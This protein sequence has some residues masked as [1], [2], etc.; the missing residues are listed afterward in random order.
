MGRR[1]KDDIPIGAIGCLGVIGLIFSPFFLIGRVVTGDTSDDGILM[2]VLIGIALVVGIS[3]VIYAIIKQV[4]KSSLQGQV[5]ANRRE[6]DDFIHSDETLEPQ[7]VNVCLNANEQAYYTEN[8]VPLGQ[9]KTVHARQGTAVGFRVFK[10]L[11]IGSY[12]SEGRSYSELRHCDKGPLILTNQNLIFRGIAE[13]RVIPLNKI[14]YVEEF[15]DAIQVS[16][17]NKKSMDYFFVRNPLLWAHLILKMR[18]G[19]LL[20]NNATH[21]PMARVISVETVPSAQRFL[22]PP[23]NPD[24]NT[25]DSFDPS[26]P[27]WSPSGSFNS[28]RSQP[29]STLEQVFMG[30]YYLLAM[31]IIRRS[32]LKPVARKTGYVN[33]DRGKA[34]AQLHPHNQG[35]VLVIPELDQRCPPCTLLHRVPFQNL[36]GYRSSNKCWMDGDGTRW[37]YSPAGAFFVPGEMENQPDHPGW[38]EVDALLAYI[39]SR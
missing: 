4:E 24:D 18:N 30:S 8:E 5:D 26:P 22:P 12:H 31:E 11:G 35:V 15:S 27:S 9:A 17:R 21:R 2:N 38:K 34:C 23:S 16:Q 33:L 10:G 20:V 29:T 25:E 1:K 39:K 3:L 36:Q 13:Q 37:T 14:L 6:L 28:N 19:E 32:G 7:P